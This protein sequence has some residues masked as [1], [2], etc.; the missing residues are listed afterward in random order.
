[1]NAILRQVHD[2]LI[3]VVYG[4]LAFTAGGAIIRA[5][6]TSWPSRILAVAA[7]VTLFWAACSVASGREDPADG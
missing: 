5:Y 6:G 1:M 2:C 3:T 4:V 7:A